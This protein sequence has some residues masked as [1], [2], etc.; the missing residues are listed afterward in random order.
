MNPDAQSPYCQSLADRLRQITLQT[1]NT[2]EARVNRI[3]DELAKVRTTEELTAQIL[4]EYLCS[5]QRLVEMEHSAAGRV[6]NGEPQRKHVLLSYPCPLSPSQIDPIVQSVREAFPSLT[7]T[8][9]IDH[10]NYLII[11]SGW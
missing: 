2:P 3:F 1:D 7:V 4:T 6:A 11:M 9:H 8:Y 5:Q 10:A